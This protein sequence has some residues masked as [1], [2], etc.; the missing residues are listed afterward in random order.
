M[1]KNKNKLYEIIQDIETK[2]ILPSLWFHLKKE[3]NDSY[4][5]NLQDCTM[6]VHTKQVP[7]LFFH[8]LSSFDDTMRSYVQLLDELNII[9]EFIV[10]II[11]NIF[12][13]ACHE[14]LHATELAYLRKFVF[15]L[16]RPLL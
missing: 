6:Y 13:H 2:Q 3:V 16:C 5:R 10:S 4:Y 15:A 11:A 8:L 9:P 12:T 1:K 7:N 14:T